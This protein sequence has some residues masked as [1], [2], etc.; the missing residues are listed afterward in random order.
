MSRKSRFSEADEVLEAALAHA[1]SKVLPF[2]L[3]TKADFQVNWHHRVLGRALDGFVSRKIRNL[4]VFMPPRLGKSELISRRLPAFIL[5]TN[6]RARI[7]ATSYSAELASSL[8]RDVQ[9]IIDSEEYRQL[10]PQTQLYGESVRT[11]A[12][13]TY[14]RNTDIFET[15]PFRGTYRSAG[16]GGGI[17]GLGA[18]YCFPAWTLVSTPSGQKYIS[19]IKAGDE[20][21]SYDHSSGQTKA[22]RVTALSQRRMSP[23]VMV[24][25]SRGSR[26]FCTPCHPI[27][28]KEFGYRA[29][30][31]LRGCTLRVQG[32]LFSGEENPRQDLLRSLP[33]GM[34]S[35]ALRIR[36]GRS[37]RKRAELLFSGVFKGL[38]LHAVPKKM[39]DLWKASSPKNADLLLKGVQAPQGQ[40]QKNNLPGVWRYIQA[41]LKVYAV[42]LQ[43]MWWPYPLSKDDGGGELELRSR[44]GIQNNLRA[45]SAKGIQTGRPPVC[46]L[47]L[48]EEGSG[49]PHKSSEAGR[50]DGKPH[51]P[52]PVLPHHP[53]QVEDEPVS[54]VREVCGGDVW[55]YDFQVEELHNFF[56]N[57]VLVHNCIID[58][59]I[60]NQAEAESETY[61]RTLH[62]W[63]R[64]TLY[65]RREKGAGICLVMQRWHDDDL[66]GRLL[67]E[68]QSDPDA[69]QWTV[70]K[71]PMISGEE[72]LPK[73]PR[74]APG[75]ALWPEKYDE[76][77]CHKIR[78]TQ[79]SRNWL[80]LYQ[81]EPSEEKG[82]EVKKGWLKTW[83]P[84]DIPQFPDLTIISVDASFKGG[85]GSSYVAIQVWLRKGPD[86]FLLDQDRRQMGFLDTV[87]AIQDMRSKWPK[88]TAVVVEDKANGPAIIETLKEKVPGV[89]G[90]QPYGSKLARLR[91]VTPFMEAGN[92]Y[93]PSP[94]THAWV[95]AYESEMMKFPNSADNDQVDTT[96]QALHY[97]QEN[98][99]TLEM[100]ITM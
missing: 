2:T 89:I 54:L 50:Q 45:A 10:F 44:E 47:R 80:A 31:D 34:G 38:R 4:M 40:A 16:V 77:E 15:V 26:L 62:E 87:R 67:K 21:W 90:C 51:H 57:G 73:D 59:P 14:L 11:T 74:P 25:G 30:K 93:I 61:R 7:I 91:A 53:P 9:F 49:S 17:V 3:W 1:R 70:I 99:S 79:G 29:A 20:V 56:A 94:E 41:R 28:T 96:S 63:Y 86:F 52:L 48:H 58:D 72:R 37:A 85:E 46:G 55:V 97:F 43:K 5:G 24:E 39:R 6:P 13:G 60:K 42:L 88:V 36:E 83:L 69:E 35:S 66:A 27:F 22:R 78:K 81:Q 32:R 68:A 19:E 76:A 64:T 92:V 84:K 18:D 82:N 8:N 100:L 65:S 12:A 71:F 75:L 98:S 33:E 95:P 23:L